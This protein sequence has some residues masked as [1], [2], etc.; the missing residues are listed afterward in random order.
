MRPRRAA[1]PYTHPG[2]GQ[3]KSL[4]RRP[5]TMKSNYSPESLPD[6]PSD[7]PVRPP[8]NAPRLGAPPKQPPKF[9]HPRDRRP[10]DSF[11]PFLRLPLELRLKIW[12]TCF[13]NPREVRLDLGV[14]KC[15]PTKLP[16]TLFVNQ[17]KK[18]LS[19]ISSS[20]CCLSSGLSQFKD[21]QALLIVGLIRK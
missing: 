3:R 9:I 20:L 14:L 2:R 12:H 6:L 17:G 13:P 4:D 11:S 10:P 8:S 1:R 15:T 5:T 16:T 18:M 19:K 21:A 7:M